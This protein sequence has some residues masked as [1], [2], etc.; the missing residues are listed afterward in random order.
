MS[1]IRPFVI[2]ALCLLFFCA[3]HSSNAGIFDEFAESINDRF[4]QGM[5]SMHEGYQH[6]KQ[7]I[8]ESEA[9]A[10]LMEKA[11]PAIKQKVQDM[12]DW[13][14]E[15]TASDGRQE[16]EKYTVIDLVEE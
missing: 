15:K 1:S 2:L 5:Q 6:A 12:K 14:H 3:V 7:A 9:H 10:W 8:K 16:D 11:F 13:I 4:N